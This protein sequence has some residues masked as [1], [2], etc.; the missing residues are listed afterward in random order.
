[1]FEGLTDEQLEQLKLRL[2]DSD[3]A[4]ARAHNPWNA[5]HPMVPELAGIRQEVETLLQYRR[6]VNGNNI[7]FAA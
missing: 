5:T 2:F 6:I 4:A 1:M 7:R 3:V